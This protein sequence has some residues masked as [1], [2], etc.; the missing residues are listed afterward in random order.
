M[1]SECHPAIPLA[2][3]LAAMFSFF[4]QD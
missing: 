1:P 4:V 3:S 2:L